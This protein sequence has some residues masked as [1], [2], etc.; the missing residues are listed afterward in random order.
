LEASEVWWVG[1]I[2]LWALDRALEVTMLRI[3]EWLKPVSGLTW[4]VVFLLY[5]TLAGSQE[6]TPKPA[7]TP[8][9]VYMQERPPL[10]VFDPGKGEDLTPLQ[11]AAQRLS[12]DRARRD[13]PSFKTIQNLA[14]YEYTLSGENEA[15]VLEDAR[16][17]AL[18]SAAARL[19]FEDYFLLGRDLLEP[20]VRQN[21]QPFI[22]RT[23]VI[24]RRF[25]TEGQVQMTVRV[26]VNL[27]MFYRDLQEKK[28]IATPNLRPIVSVHLLELIDGKRDPSAN[29]RSRIEQTMQNNLF[30]VF[31]KKMTDV[32]LD[33]DLSSSPELLQKA[34]LEAQRQDVDILITGVLS[35]RPINDNQILFDQYVFQEAE[36]DLKMYRVDTGEL[37]TEQNTHYSARGYDRDEAIKN[38]LDLMLT[39]ISKNLAGQVR[40]VWGN[41]MLDEGNVRLMIS[42]VERGQITGIYNFLQT[43]SP[44]LKLFE[45]AYYGNVVVVNVVAPGTDPEKIEEFLRQSSEPQFTVR[46]ID[47]R[48]FELELL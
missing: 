16:V 28:F 17:H 6:P 42:G 21:G 41:T 11:K 15:K 24:D 31:S 4:A 44:Q 23:T 22:A 27:D 10:K 3:F 25:L 36:V 1:Q 14:T 2:G 33:A 46:R 12:V 20:Y 37:M 29:A 40:N 47:D 19:Y 39:A 38:V 7:E 35:V 30:R 43:L 32:P 45:K 34:R 48:R 5:G 26:S 18:K 8:A 9:P 13:R